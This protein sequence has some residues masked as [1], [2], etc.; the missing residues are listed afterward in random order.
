M[1][2]DAGRDKKRDIPPFTCPGPTFLGGCLS[3]TQRT[4][5]RLTSVG[6]RITPRRTDNHALVIT[7]ASHTTKHAERRD[8]RLGHAT[9]CMYGE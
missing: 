4:R 8:M 9:T 1:G 2:K 6:P 3:C 7:T 5:N